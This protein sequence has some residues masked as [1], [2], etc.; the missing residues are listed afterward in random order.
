MA[1]LARYLDER[2]PDELLETDRREAYE[3]ACTIQHKHHHAMTLSRIAR[4]QF[5][6][7]VAK[8]CEQFESRA[9]QKIEKLV[10]GQKPGRVWQTSCSD[11]L[12]LGLCIRR[13]SLHHRRQMLHYKQLSSGMFRIY[14]PFVNSLPLKLK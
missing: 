8:A 12:A 2:R 13:I 9:L 14:L 6:A 5:K 7:H 3:A 11:P 4:Q 1:A 10:F